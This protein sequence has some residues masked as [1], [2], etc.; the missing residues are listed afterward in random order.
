MGVLDCEKYLFFIWKI[1]IFLLILNIHLS[2]FKHYYMTA[3]NK[4]QLK[5]AN[6]SMHLTYKDVMSFLRCERAKATRT[7]QKIRVHFVLPKGTK[8][9][10]YQYLDYF[11]LLNLL[12]Q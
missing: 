9:T 10:L 7:I 3:I 2:I 11:N 6:L 4:E 1:R 8:I 5:N 12:P